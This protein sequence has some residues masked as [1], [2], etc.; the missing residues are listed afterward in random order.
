[1]SPAFYHIAHLIGFMLLLLGL[2][3]AAAGNESSR[4]TGMK[5]HGIGLVIMFI[6]GF[7]LLAKLQLSYTSAWV[8]AK[9]VIWLLLGALPV[10][11]KKGILTGQGMMIVALVL[12]GLAASMGYLKALPFAG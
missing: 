4:K 3:A 9:V 2:G 8:I 10:L 6:A 12:G 5:F 1:M 11:G 7:G